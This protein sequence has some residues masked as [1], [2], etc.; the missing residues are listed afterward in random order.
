MPLSNTPGVECNYIQV[1][2]GETKNAIALAE[3]KSREEACIGVAPHIY[4]V[5]AI[6]CLRPSSCLYDY[7]DI[8]GDHETYQLSVPPK[9]LKLT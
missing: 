1:L 8:A 6:R 7:A 9:R 2:E 4:G 5:A 3:T